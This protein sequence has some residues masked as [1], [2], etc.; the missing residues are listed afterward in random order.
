MASLTNGLAL[1]IFVLTWA[2]LAFLGTFWFTNIWPLGFVGLALLGLLAWSG[3][4]IPVCRG[5]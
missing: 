5:R 1:K 3:L 4:R 2:G